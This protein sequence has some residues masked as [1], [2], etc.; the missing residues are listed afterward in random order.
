MNKEKTMSIIVGILVLI[1]CY[2]FA[3]MLTV[4]SKF[5]NEFECMTWVSKDELICIVYVSK[6]Y[7][8][9]FLPRFVIEE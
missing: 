7:R 2:G 1:I 4:I 3:E 6:E 9:M 8:E 5:L